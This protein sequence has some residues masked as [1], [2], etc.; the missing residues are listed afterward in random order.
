MLIIIL[1]I[2]GVSVVLGVIF[3]LK[4][5]DKPT[6]TKKTDTTPRCPKCKS[7]SISADK[8]GFGVGKAVVGAAIAGP[9][10]LAGGN[11]GAKKV[12]ITC[13][14]CRHQWMAGKG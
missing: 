6:E 10:G 8:K 2:L 13:L 12:R 3:G 14:N 1:V 11:I 4:G 5:V 9:L 7:T